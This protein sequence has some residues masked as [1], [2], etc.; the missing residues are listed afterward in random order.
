M[1][2]ATLQRDWLYDLDRGM[3]R[4]IAAQR[5]SVEELWSLPLADRVND[6]RSLGPLD[7]VEASKEKVRLVATTNTASLASCSM[8]EGDFVRLSRD[9][10]RNPDARCIFLG[11]DHAGIHL[12]LS[13]GSAPLPAGPGWTIDPDFIDLTERFAEAIDALAGS[14]LGRERILPLL[15]GAAASELDSERFEESLEEIAEE[16]SLDGHAWHESQ[17]EAIAACV[18]ARDAFLVQ[19]PPGTGK[20]RVLGEVARRLLEQ[21]QRLLVTGPTHRAIQQAL[22]AVRAIVSPNVRVAKIGPVLLGGAGGVECHEGY[23]ES[24]LHDC[25]EP[26]VIGATPHA[27]WSK[28]LGLRE[29]VFDTVLLDEASQLTPLLAAMAMLRGERWLFFGDDCQL[30]PVVV[31]DTTTPARHRSV[32]GVLKN[33]DFDHMLTETWRLSRLLAA[34][35][36]ATFYGNRLVARHDRRIRIDPASG[37][38][39][40]TPEP[41]M[42]MREFTPRRCTVRSD[43]EAQHA[44]QLVRELVRGGVAPHAIGIITPFRAQAGRIRQ[45]LA[46]QPEAS[47]LHRQVITDTVE[48]F[49][50]QERDVIVVSFAA[51]DPAFIE[52]RAD[53]LLQRERLNVAVTRAR[54]KTILLVS[55]GLLETAESLAEAG[56]EGATCFSSL[57]RHLRSQCPA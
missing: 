52:R 51:S 50:G 13:R 24:G 28:H 44:A 20:T 53:F 46:I 17:Q 37:L 14:R 40:L 27:L 39:E 42:V 57:V 9:T 7:V 6:G 49:Q 30:P 55:R 15:T 16:E 34:W 29:A 8:R 3:R 25:G 1:D 22:E 33:R 36:S 38:P 54:L 48:R 23:V 56:H 18:A 32:F 35:P 31:S 4:E 47:G 5:A 21:G 41:A 11:E 45:L 10:P 2:P 12:H 19:G 43:E 26:H